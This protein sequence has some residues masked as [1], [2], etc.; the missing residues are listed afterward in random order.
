MS[1]YLYLFLNLKIQQIMETEDSGKFNP[2]NK[3]PGASLN[4]KANYEKENRMRD[5]GV[6]KGVITTAII[7]FLILLVAGIVVYSLYNREHNRFF[8]RWKRRRVYLQRK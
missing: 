5:E 8:V 4:E 3:N 2:A 7:S 6:K 1:P